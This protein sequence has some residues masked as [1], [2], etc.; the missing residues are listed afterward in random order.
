[1]GNDKLNSFQQ[2][3]NKATTSFSPFIKSY[4]ERKKSSTSMTKY[5][6]KV[7]IAKL[8]MTSIFHTFSLYHF[9]NF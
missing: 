3:H 9:E 2:N 5:R 1:M 7:F 8:P 6:N 4:L